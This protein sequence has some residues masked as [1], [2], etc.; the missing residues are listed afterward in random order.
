VITTEWLSEQGAAV[1]IKGELDLDTAPLLAAELERQ[2]TDGHRH[3]VI[4]LTDTVFLDSTSLG[5]LVRAIQP[6]H[7]EPDAAV[8]L[9]GAGGVVARAL[10]TSGI[11]QLFT[12]FETRREADRAVIGSGLCDGWRAVRRPT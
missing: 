7:D 6:L 5:T 3:L 10:L 2:I 12:M 8:V 1:V 4:D 9:A 11:G